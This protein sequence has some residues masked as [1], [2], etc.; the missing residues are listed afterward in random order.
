MPA[1]CTPLLTTASQAWKCLTNPRWAMLIT[2][3]PGPLAALPAQA[4][5]LPSETAHSNQSLR[6][7]FGELDPQMQLELVQWYSAE[8]QAANTYQGQLV[9]YVFAQID[10]DPRDWPESDPAPPLYSAQKHTPAQ[11]IAREFIK[12]PSAAQEKWIGRVF[13]SRATSPWPSPWS[14]DYARG[15]VTRA[16]P[17]PT[18]QQHAAHVFELALHG[19]VPD[20]DLAQAIVA[21]LL[22]SRTQTA[23][24]RAFS[25]AYADRQGNAHSRVTLYDAWGSGLEMEMPDVECL[26]IIHDLRDDWDTWVAPIPVHQHDRLYEQ[27]GAIYVNLRAEREMGQA[28]AAT[29]VQGDPAL[30]SVYLA[31]R[32]RLHALW[33]E[34]GTSPKALAPQLP[35]SDNALRVFW[36]TRGKALDTN[37]DLW[38]AGQVRRSALLADQ[39]TVRKTLLWVMQQLKILPEGNTSTDP[40]IPLQSG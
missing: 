14:Y 22:D 17:R 16:G 28:L 25:H 38:K 1:P 29:Y 7:V 18:P 9:R 20:A 40:S 23:A 36:N 11:V 2:L 21:S 26:G 35:T 31:H 12:T 6:A 30:A 3:L 37:R 4:Q 34:V 33:A 32:D 15:L 5:Q 8:I 27:I 19:Q 10:R 13:R 39:I 24:H